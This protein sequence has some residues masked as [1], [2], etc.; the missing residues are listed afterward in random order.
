M[1]YRSL[2]LATALAAMTGQALAGVPKFLD[3]RAFAMG[4]VGVTSARPAA[5][6]F[7]NPALLAVEQKEKSDSFG[8]L[9]PSLN[10]VARDEDE[11]I[12]TADDFEKDYLE[13]F[14]AA[15]EN[16]DTTN[17][18]TIDASN[19]ELARQAT[20]LNDEM[21]RI[22]NDQSLIEAGL[23]FSFQIP[24][25]DL[26]IGVFVST[27][28]RIAATLSYRDQTLLETIIQDATD[29]VYNDPDDVPYD[30]SEDDLQSTVRGVGAASAQ[31]GVN[32]A[33]NFEFGGHQVALGVS[34]KVVDFRAYDFSYRADSFDDFDSDELKETKVSKNGFNF[35]LGAAAFLDRDK[36]W[37]AG[38]AIINVL[39][40]KVQTKGTTI[41]ANDISTE[42]VDVPG[43]KVELKPVVTAGLSYAGDAYVVAADVDLTKTKP[44][45]NEDD[46]QYLGLGAEYDFFETFQLRAGARHNIAGSANTLLS[47]GFGF[48]ILGGTIEL[49]GM[50]D[51]GSDTVGASLQFGA[52]F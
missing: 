8:M 33:R 31:A 28:A 44:L 42:E 6:S 38:L 29:G 40:M 26:G 4:G 19:E 15:I 24:A 5:S 51:S 35:D 32:L 22:N 37:L 14:E 45:L 12:D 13:P 7:Y 3:A 10:V 36:R 48:N 18:V 21:E 30:L 17:L 43:L 46:V 52:S 2:A 41:P 49:A 25:Q 1:K 23:G 11:L 39:P 34:P 20:R 16:Y 27:T 50:T 9:L 47:A